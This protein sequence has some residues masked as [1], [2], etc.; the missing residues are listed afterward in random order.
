MRD[1]TA[2]MPL[3]ETPSADATSAGAKTS[4]T[5]ASAEREAVI[6]TDKL[7]KTFSSE[8][9]QQHVLKNLDLE[10]INGDF[11][12]IMGPSG[13]GKSTLLYALS[14]IDTPTLG[15]VT[16]AGTEISDLGQD[17]LAAFR[18]RHCG[19]VFQQINLLDSMSAM[20]N[21]M[22]AG[23]LIGRRSAVARRAAELLDRVGID[24]NLRS[25]TP[26]QL[27]GGEAQRV[28]LVRALI[29]QPDVVFADEP[30]G[31]LNSKSST[32]VLD[33]L[34]DV[35]T[36]GQTIVMVTHDVRTAVRGSRILYLRDGTIRGTLDLGRYTPDTN[37]ERTAALTSFLTEMGW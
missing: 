35:H 2:K 10:I 36:D 17:K 8:G 34:T 31:K 13:A 37:E 33:L 5:A 3:G 25:K 21:V 29:N 1:S 16:F 28:A 15:T 18:R 19:F 4:S 30:T 6:L 32:R 24:E 14:G 11:T 9:A 23:L 26:A 7:S 22:V 12:V 27:S 20:D